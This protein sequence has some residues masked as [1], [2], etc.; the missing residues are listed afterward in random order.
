MIYINDLPDSSQFLYSTLF[1]DD[2]TLSISDSCF[3]NLIP[4]LNDELKTIKN[5]AISNKLSINVEKTEIIKITNKINDNSER[6]VKLR[7]DILRL[8][9]SCVF[10]GVHIDKNLNFSLHINYINSKISKN[11]DIFLSNSE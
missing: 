6:Q 5:W 7:E 9:K 4:L 10:L 3:N 8:E 1:A 11:T 2:T